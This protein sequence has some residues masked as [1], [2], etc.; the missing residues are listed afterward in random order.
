MLASYKIIS[1]SDRVATRHPSWHALHA[2]LESGASQRQNAC[3][4]TRSQP[5]VAR[6]LHSLPDSVTVAEAKLSVVPIPVKLT[7]LLK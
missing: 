2:R 1:R 7:L 3:M 5:N 4:N 6:D